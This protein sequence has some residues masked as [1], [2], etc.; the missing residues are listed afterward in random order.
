M[1]ALFPTPRRAAGFSLA[2][3]MI[4]MAIGLIILAGMATLFVNNNRTADEVEKANR[5]LETGRLALQTL[6]I[7]ARNAGYYAEFD[8]INM[9]LPPSLPLP[10]STDLTVIEAALPLVVQGYDN[11]ASTMSTTLSCL[12]G[13]KIGTDVLVIRRTQTCALG[14]GNCE[15]ASAGGIF[16]QASM[17]NGATELQS[18]DVANHFDI[19]TAT[20]DLT[21]TMRNCTAA[22]PMYRLVTHIYYIGSDNVT[23][24]GIPTLKRAELGGTTLGFTIVP[25]AEGVENMQLEYGMDSDASTDLDVAPD[26]F[27]SSPATLE[28][29]RDVVSVR[30]SLL[31]RNLTATPTHIDSKSY[32][33]GSTAVAAANDHYKR[34]VFESLVS[35]PNPSGRKMPQ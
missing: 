6:S 28:D 35:L 27:S 7:D 11:Y 14:V 24:D 17:C 18:T 15:A 3:M 9:G 29:W 33:L 4:S 12:T 13:V 30:I 2:E 34:H 16:L 26:S 10:C 22:A 23:G 32:K 25:L 20:T 5:Q 19:G 8:P 31:A 1:Q 21:R